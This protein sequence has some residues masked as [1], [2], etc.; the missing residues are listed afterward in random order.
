MR[1][2]SGDI[3]E[4]LAATTDDGRELTLSQLA[5]GGFLVIFFYP[6]AFTGGCTAQTCHFRDLS[7]EFAQL[8]ASLVGV[9]RDDLNTQARFAQEHQLGFPLLTDPDG[10]LVDAFGVSRPGPL[11]NKRRTFVLDRELRVLGVVSNETDMDAHA[12][13]ALALLRDH[14]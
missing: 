9:S 5:D 2:E 7:S 10:E 14:G 3:V 13:D 8:G 12:D 1:V 4:D 6:K 11:P